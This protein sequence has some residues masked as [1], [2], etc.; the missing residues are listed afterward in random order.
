MFERPVEYLGQGL[1]LGY[2]EIGNLLPNNQ[3]QRRTC[4]STVLLTVPRVGRSYE[5][6]PDG[7]DLH[8]LHLLLLPTYPCTLPTTPAR[9]F[10]RLPYPPFLGFHGLERTQNIAPYIAPPAHPE[11]PEAPAYRQSTRLWLRAIPCPPRQNP[12]RPAAPAP[13]PTSRETRETPR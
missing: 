7:F 10:H 2:R 8:L 13:L 12:T 9:R 1:S 4:L 11:P 6:F 5:L 3:R